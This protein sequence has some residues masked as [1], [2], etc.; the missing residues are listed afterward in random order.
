[1][2]ILYSG[3]RGRE[4]DMDA[5]IICIGGARGPCGRKRDRTSPEKAVA[6]E[7]FLIQAE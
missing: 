5:L 1:M 4:N 2:Q 6:G 7:L 3:M